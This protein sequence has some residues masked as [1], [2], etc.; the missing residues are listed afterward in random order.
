MSA[1]KNLIGNNP[2]V[3]ITKDVK[4]A[5]DYCKKPDTRFAG[6]WEFGK[7]PT[8]GKRTDLADLYSDIKA[9]KTCSEL[10]EANPSVARFEKYIK[11]MKFSVMEKASD[12]QTQGVKVYIFWGD[13]DL[14]KTYTAFNI[15]DPGHIFKMDP[16]SVKNSNLW[17]DGYEGERTLLLDEFKGDNYCSIDRLKTL[18]DVYKC[19]LD[20]KGSFS[21]AAWT[22]VIICSNYAPRDW[23]AVAPTDAQRVLAPLKRRI[24]QI[25]HFTARGIY[26]EED[27][28]GEHIGDLKEVELPPTQP[29][30]AAAADADDDDSIQM[31]DGDDVIA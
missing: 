25:R 24:Y 13:T 16:P 17:F 1:I 14:G 9:G 15:M 18:L 30:A 31:V 10:L 2:H 12:R 28:D 26:Q 6:P 11:F 20:V 3:E 27:W 21:W 8:Q 23:Y 29:V 19:R 5:S 22:T 7:L 4:G